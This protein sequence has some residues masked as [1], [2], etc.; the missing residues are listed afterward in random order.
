MRMRFL[1][2]IHAWAN[3]RTQEPETAEEPAPPKSEPATDDPV[4][5]SCFEFS[6]PQRDTLI[7]VENRGYEVLIRATRDTF[8]DRQKATFVEELAAE[9]FIPQACHWCS[10]T[11]FRD[12]EGPDVRWIIDYSWLELT[13]QVLA[14]SRRFM[15]RLFV[16]AGLIWLGLVATL[17]LPSAH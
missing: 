2:V 8:T 3:Q 16:G 7:Q 15:M 17:F 11:P 10:T 12:P 14:P 13:E 9:G 6:F 1:D 5:P 4:A